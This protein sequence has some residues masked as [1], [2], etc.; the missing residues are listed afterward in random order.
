[1]VAYTSGFLVRGAVFVQLLFNCDGNSNVLVLCTR[2][3]HARRIYCLPVKFRA[4]T[5]PHC[6]QYRCITEVTKA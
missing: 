1:M 6:V 3:L 5:R 4:N 2:Y